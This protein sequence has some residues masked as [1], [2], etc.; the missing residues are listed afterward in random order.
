MTINNTPINN[1]YPVANAT[2]SDATFVDVIATRDPTSNDRNY[3][4]QKKWLNSTTNSLWYLKSFTPTSTA[5]L[6]N[7]VLI[8]SGTTPAEKLQGNSGGAVSPDGSNIIHTIGDGVGI[9]VVGNP[10]TN[11]LTWSLAGGGIA[12][13]KFQ[14]D[15]FTAPGTNPVAPTALGLVTVTGGQVPAG[16]TGNVIQTNSLA[17]NTYTIQVQRSQAVAS[18]T[19]SDN[20]VSHFKSADFAVDSNG[21][22][23]LVTPSSK[24]WINQ[25]K[26][27]V[28]DTVG[29]NTYTPTSGMVYC[30]VEVVGGGGGSG[31]CEATGATTFAVSGGGGAGGYSRKLLTAATVGV[32]QTVT[33]GAAGTAGALGD[34]D[35]GTGGTTSFGA[36]LQAT[37]GAGGDGGL[38]FGFMTSSFGGAGGAGSG[39]D[40]NT[41]GEPGQSGILT[42]AGGAGFTAIGGKGG[43]SFFGGGGPNNGVNDGPG[44]AAFSY[45]GGGGG[46][47][48]NVM[49]AAKT[50]AAGF[51]GVCIVTEYISA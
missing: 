15:A 24:G 7:W 42:T 31:G 1:L 47:G 30:D 43:N 50:G 12:T 39:G 29:A 36:I 17:A 11:T 48:T 32:S 25:V 9:T 3:Q 4:T 45:G 10:G 27:Q 49:Q 44:T 21:F 16:T 14:V 34:N 40:F 35:G 37:G 41:T 22:V 5:M 19:I 28:F 18:S 23:S 6:A 8:T 26:R 38:A 20:G 13:E 33:V 46:A 51:K 2:T